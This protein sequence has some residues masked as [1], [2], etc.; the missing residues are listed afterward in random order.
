MGIYSREEKQE[1]RNLEKDVEYRSMKNKICKIFVDGD[2]CPVFNE[3]ISV[4]KKS[5]TQVVYVTSYAHIRKEKFPPI[6]DSVFVD[7]DREAADL[8]IA[9]E[10][11]KN[12][13]AV[14]DDLGLSS[15]LLAKG[16]RV[17]TSRGKVITDDNIDFLLDSR[18][19][20]AKQRRAGGRTKGPK[21]LTDADRHLFKKELE[22]ILSY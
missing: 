12:D 7:Q 21:K 17:L 10:I 9:N 20:S 15:L 5:E 11:T 1:R 22:N 4:A 14:T 16:V 13:V 2:A 18:Y 19:R 3:I 6:V 8:K